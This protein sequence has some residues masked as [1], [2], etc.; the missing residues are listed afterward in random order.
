M[1]DYSEFRRG[2]PLLFVSTLGVALGLSPIPF[3]ELGLFAPGFVRDF[4]WS[5][6]S[7]M[8]GLAAV[9]LG[10]LA[11]SPIV[12]S[13]ADRYGPRRIVLT[14]I[15]CFGFS[16][17]LFA[18]QNG[19]LLF[20]YATWF[21]LALAGAGTLPITWTRAVNQA[22]EVRKGLALGLTLAGSGISGFFLKPLTAVFIAEFGWRSA[23][24][25]LASLPLLIAFPLAW[26][27][28]RPPG[29]VPADPASAAR[30]D[31]PS[32]GRSF[33]QAVRDWRFWLIGVAMLLAAFAVAGPIPNIEAILKARG[34][35]PRSV[36][37]ITPFLGLA[38]IVGRVAGGWLL[39]RLWAPAVAMG[40]FALSA[41]AMWLLVN[42]PAHTSFAW[43]G[44]LGIGI[45]AGVEFDLTAFLSARY[46]GTRHYGKIYGV[47]SC[48]FVLGSGVAPLIY[49]RVY[50]ATKRFDIIV[51]LGAALILLAGILILTLGRYRYARSNPSGT[52]A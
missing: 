36:L 4:Q 13:L 27:L 19:S 42:E 6:A 35:E 32:Q 10:I 33:E 46:F 26:F 1:S 30:E 47:L 40:L 28:F 2:W 51:S 43:T 45:L 16:L 39:D 21:L 23:F 3:Y 41:G 34:L 44:V 31:S 7:I 17:S 24:V 11:A 38:V 25:V 22:F 9:T 50:D 12:G 29:D 48:F 49:G 5:M 52:T 14:S 8:G 18:L 37:Q 15:V 20:Y